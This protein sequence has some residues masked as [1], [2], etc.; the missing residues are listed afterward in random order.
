MSGRASLITTP[1]FIVGLRQRTTC[2]RAFQSL[3]LI[4]KWL[5]PGL[6]LTTELYASVS[7]QPCR[8]LGL[9]SLTQ[10]YWIP[11]FRC[12]CIWIRNQLGSYDFALHG[13]EVVKSSAPFPE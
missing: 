8:I 4:S 11:A 1:D 2:T 9:V 13:P 7:T 5:K 3:P 10:G 6:L 12:E